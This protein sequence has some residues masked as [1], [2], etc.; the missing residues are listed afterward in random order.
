MSAVV[1]ADIKNIDSIQASGTLVGVGGFFAFSRCFVRNF[2]ACVAFH[3]EEQNRFCMETFQTRIKMSN[4]TVNM[5][6]PA[7]MVEDLQRFLANSRMLEETEEGANGE[8][9]AEEEEA[10]S[11]VCT[12]RR[13]LAHRQGANGE[14]EFRV[15]W[16]SD[17]STEW[18]RDEDCNTGPLISDYLRANKIKTAYLFCRVSTKEQAGSTSLS[19]QAQETALRGAVPGE[20]Q[21]VRVFSISK[22]AYTSIPR[23]LEEIGEAAVEG[24][25]I[26]VWRVDRLSRNII[27]YL[28][29]C[30]DLANRGITIYSQQD[31]LSYSDDRLAFI[32]AIVD[33]Q[34]EA[35]ILGERVKAAFREKRRRGDEHIGNLPYGKRYKRLMGPDG[36]TDRMVVINDPNETDII[37]RIRTSQTPALMAGLLNDAGIRKRGRKWTPAMVMRL[38]KQ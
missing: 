11:P 8:D 28:D 6:V 29:W 35:M 9:A 33:A 21:R 19:L 7:D 18:V 30:E 4:A 32:Q 10:S 15:Q 27:H 38:H 24:D 34:K 37:R 13:V 36:R 1:G 31:N 16:A 22:S 12:V 20:F 14:F 5:E 23:V 26:M 25:A 17:N 3:C 2:V